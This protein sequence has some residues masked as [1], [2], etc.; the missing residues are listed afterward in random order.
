MMPA[1]LTQMSNAAEVPTNLL[2]T[3]AD[4]RLI[5]QIDRH[6]RCLAA[7]RD[8]LVA[9]SVQLVRIARHQR[10]MRACR[11]QTDRHRLAEAAAGPGH[12]G[13]FLL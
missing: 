5:G 9:N 7:C 10:H 6:N 3:G 4:C 11:R 1:L 13:D 8:N 12:D 2:H